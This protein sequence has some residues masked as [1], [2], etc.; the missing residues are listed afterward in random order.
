MFPG[1][2]AV[3]DGP[4]AILGFGR[5]FRVKDKVKPYSSHSAR[6]LVQCEIEQTTRLSSESI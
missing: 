1:C 3:L 4:R 6:V 2:P 5:L